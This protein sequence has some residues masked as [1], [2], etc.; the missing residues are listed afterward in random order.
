RAA[1]RLC[2]TRKL[3]P[4]VNVLVESGCQL[5]FLGLRFDWELGFGTSTRRVARVRTPRIANGRY[6]M[7][8]SNIWLHFQRS[9]VTRMISFAFATWAIGTTRSTV[10]KLKIQAESRGS[11]PPSMFPRGFWLRPQRKKSMF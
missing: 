5:D 6:A 11:A 8:R 4:I 1:T 9:L 10:C 3:F 2:D 7:T